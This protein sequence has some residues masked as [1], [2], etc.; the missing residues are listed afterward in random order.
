MNLMDV[1]ECFVD[2][3]EPRSTSEKLDPGSLSL[4][5]PWNP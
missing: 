5:L 2:A 3:G 4:T 1:S